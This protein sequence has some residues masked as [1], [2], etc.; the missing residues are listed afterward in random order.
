[1]D[2]MTGGTKTDPEC[3][4]VYRVS[5]KTSVNGDKH[6]SNGRPAAVVETSRRAVHALTRTT[7]PDRNARTLTSS[8]N[9]AIGLTKD[10]YWTD[11]N[12]RP[13]PRSAL[14]DEALC[15]Y[16]GRLPGDETRA[17][18]AFWATSV[19]LGRKNL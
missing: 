8:K 4:D 9:D 18:E 10:A 17:L 16:L 6:G 12:Q 14:A 3:G 1:M 2:F 11:V 15:R 7:N 13:L 19:A 5:P